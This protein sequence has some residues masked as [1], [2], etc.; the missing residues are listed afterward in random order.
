MNSGEHNFAQTSTSDQSHYLNSY[1]SNRFNGNYVADN[2][3]MDA[4][5]VGTYVVHE[6]V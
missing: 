2:A 1:C 6:L 4:I 3:V 5:N